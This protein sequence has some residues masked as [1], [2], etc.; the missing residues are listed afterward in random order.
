M[1]LGSHPFFKL[2]ILEDL[3]EQIFKKYSINTPYRK[4]HFLS[5]IDHE[6]NGFKSFRE[7]LNYSV[8]GLLKTFSRT[9]ISSKDCQLYGRT[10]TKRA[11]QTQIA[12]IIYGGPF[13]RKNLGNIAVNDGSKFIG[14]GAIQLTGRLNYTKYSAASG[15]DFLSN[16][17]LLETLPWALDVAGW[18]W[19]ISNLNTIADQE[20]IT[21][22]NLSLPTTPIYRITKKING[23]FNGLDHRYSLFVSYLKKYQNV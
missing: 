16:P 8:E 18:F 21:P 2:F 12:N 1:W 20:I 15:V 11:N 7:S 3:L 19:S 9:R 5:Q 17:S 4:A 13:G 22:S 14:R 6:S 23:G 10:R